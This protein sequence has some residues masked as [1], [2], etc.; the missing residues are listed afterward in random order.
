M[1]IQKYVA[2]TIIG[3]SALAAASSTVQA[4]IVHTVDYQK[5]ANVKVFVTPYKYEAD[6]VVYK[7][8]FVQ[9]SYGNKGIWY[10]TKNPAAANKKIYFIKHRE[11]ADLVVCF[12]TNSK[13]AGWQKKKKQYLFR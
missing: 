1:S 4:Q 3:I 13:E 7:T 8:Q 12:T 11:E 9:N 5:Q 6:L 2:A 10:Y